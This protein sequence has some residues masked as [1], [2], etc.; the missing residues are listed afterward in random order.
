LDC[1]NWHSPSILIFEKKS[2]KEVGTALGLNDDAAQKCVTRAV[3]KLRVFF[4]DHDILLPAAALTTILASQTVHAV[5][6]QTAASI[7]VAA[8]NGGAVSTVTAN[9]VKESLH[10][11][12]WT[13]LKPIAAAGCAAAL[14]IGGIALVAQHVPANKSPFEIRLVVD[15]PGP[16]AQWMTNYTAQQPDG[17]SVGKIALLDHTGVKE[18]AVQQTIAGQTDISV[19]LSREGA[20]HFA[21]ITR[22]NIGRRLAIIID[23]E[24][25]AAPTVL[26]EIP[27]GK[28]TISGNFTP[29]QATNLAIRINE[30]VRR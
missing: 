18:V 6:A 24:L 23:G 21:E 8:T 3:D 22:T 11:L 12:T 10:M 28:F 16:N 2:L 4:R 7:L 19:T 1:R 26:S 9:I 20:N 14:G 5:P 30:S 27:S 29:E 17:L 15:G 25:Y 13:K